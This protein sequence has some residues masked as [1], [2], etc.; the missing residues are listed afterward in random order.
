VTLLEALAAGVIFLITG[1]IL[2]MAFVFR[3]F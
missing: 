2:W 1:V 3:P